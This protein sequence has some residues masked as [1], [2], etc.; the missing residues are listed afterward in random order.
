MRSFYGEKTRYEPPPEPSETPSIESPAYQSVPLPIFS[1][2]P[3]L[4]T[5]TKQVGGDLS[6]WT[7]Q[8]PGE[9]NGQPHEQIRRH[10]YNLSLKQEC[11]HC[12]KSVPTYIDIARLTAGPHCTEC[13]G[14]LH[15]PE[16]ISYSYLQYELESKP[17]QSIISNFDGYISDDPLLESESL[18][19]S[20][21]IFH[22]GAPMGSGKTFLIYQRARE[23]AEDRC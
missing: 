12:Q 11:P 4:R 9:V 23:A 5:L 10:L 8:Y 13:N 7:W 22:L 3:E 16:S 21:G 15:K 18:W 20:G 2:N 6:D 17:E 1:K 14:H 19:T